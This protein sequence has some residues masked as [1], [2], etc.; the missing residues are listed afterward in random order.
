MDRL[1]AEATVDQSSPVTVQLDGHDV[2]IRPLRKW[3][4]SAVTALREGNFEV[5]ARTSLDED[6]RAL[7]QRIDPTIDDIETMFAQWAELTGQSPGE[8]PASQR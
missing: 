2:V 3:R 4:S 7:W 8:S 6:S 1:Q 5:W